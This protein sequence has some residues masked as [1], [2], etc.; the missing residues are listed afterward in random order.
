MPLPPFL[1]FP[2]LLSSIPSIPPKH[3]PC[4]LLSSINIPLYFFSV[5][6]SHVTI[7]F[8]SFLPQSFSPSFL[9][10]FSHCSPRKDESLFSTNS[11][12]YS[13]ALCCLL[14]PS[15]IILSF[16]SLFLFHFPSF[17][18]LT[19]TQFLFPLII[20]SLFLSPFP[21]SNSIFTSIVLCFLLFPSNTIFSFLSFT[22][23]FTFLL[24]LP[25]C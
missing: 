23:H 5:C 2:S 21:S 25:A 16:L 22:L 24:S 4:L 17:S 12:I 14:F 15:N 9:V 8:Y 18:P 19:P 20:V 10:S 6:R 3:N 11:F 1:H 13:I 7:S